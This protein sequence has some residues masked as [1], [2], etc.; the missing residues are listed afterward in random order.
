MLRM[1][2]P[3][4]RLAYFLMPHTCGACIVCSC[5]RHL[6]RLEQ[7]HEIEASKAGNSSGRAS[8]PLEDDRAQA[9]LQHAAQ[10][11][12]A[13]FDGIALPVIHRRLDNRVLLHGVQRLQ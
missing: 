2:R 12:S 9:L 1:L 10:V 4:Q 11:G 8:P 6:R 3:V 7:R 13:L 5:R